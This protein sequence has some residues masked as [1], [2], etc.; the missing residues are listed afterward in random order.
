MEYLF[1]FAH[2][3][4]LGGHEQDSAQR[5]SV[6]FCH[7]YR[8]HKQPGEHA[9]QG[10]DHGHDRVAQEEPD[11]STDATLVTREETEVKNSKTFTIQ[12]I[13]TF[14]PSDLRFF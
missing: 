2:L 4:V 11:I 14:L 5:A 3:D 13:L 9:G 7:R 8:E 6:H 12:W 1:P 10:V